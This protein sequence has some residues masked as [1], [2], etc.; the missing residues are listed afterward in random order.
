MSKRML[1]HSA[2]EQY[3][4]LIDRTTKYGNR[5]WEYGASNDSPVEDKVAAFERQLIDDLATGK[6]TLWD[7]YALKDK[8]LGCHCCTPRNPD[9]PC[10]GRVLQAAIPTAEHLLRENNLITE[11]GRRIIWEFKDGYRYLSNFYTFCVAIEYQ[12]IPWDSTE[13]P[14]QYSKFHIWRTMYLNGQTEV[15]PPFDIIDMFESNRVTPSE[16]K[17]YSAAYRMPPVVVQAFDASKDFIMESLVESKFF[18]NK[19][20]AAKLLNTHDYELVEG[21]RWNDKY[22]GYC[23]NKHQGENK[24]GKILMRVRDK[25]RS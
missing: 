11:D 17:K 22:W 4:V 3:D 1:V 25:L 2:F 5:Y 10:H 14:Y 23:L 21:N 16:S 20:L 8:V 18:N 13:V 24:L 6:L 15:A 12:G 9:A 7:I 19:D